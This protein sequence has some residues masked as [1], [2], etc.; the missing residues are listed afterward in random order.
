[1]CVLFYSFLLFLLLFYFLFY[2]D[3]LQWQQRALTCN[4]V[5]VVGRQGSARSQLKRWAARNEKVLRR[6]SSMIN[7][8]QTESQPDYAMF[9]VALR[10]LLILALV[11]AY[12]S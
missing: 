10:E 3:D 12:E 5:A 4:V 7:H 6:T 1:M 9:A 8:L 11:T 2:L